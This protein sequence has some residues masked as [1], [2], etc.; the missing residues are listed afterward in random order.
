MRAIGLA[1]S[2]LAYCGVAY[3]TPADCGPRAL[4]PAPANLAKILKDHARWLATQDSPKPKGKQADLSYSDLTAVDLAGAD[5]KMAK[6]T[7]SKLQGAKLDGAVLEMAELSCVLADA[8]SFAGADLFQATLTNASL[9]GSKFEQAKLGGAMLSNTELANT[10]FSGADM[11]RANLT[12]AALRNTKLNEA[13]FADV[14]LQDALWQP[15]DLPEVGTMGSATNLRTMRLDTQSPDPGGMTRLVAA[16]REAGLEDRAKEVAHARERAMISLDF[17]K[18]E[19]S[20]DIVSFGRGWLRLVAGCLTD[21]G[22][23]LTLGLVV[24][25]AWNLLFVPVYFGC[26]FSRRPDRKTGISRILPEKTLVPDPAGERLTT[27]DRVERLAPRTLGGR[28]FW[29]VCFAGVTAVRSGIG[30]FNLLEGLERFVGWKVM[31]VTGWLGWFA[32]AQALVSAFIIGC[33][34][35]AYFL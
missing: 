23:S 32:N 13:R 4:A 27:E 21:Y 28:L 33:L 9:I 2:L 6:F 11:R 19:K 18:W 15:V 1:L 16:L 17:A 34:V 24:V 31:A 26:G 8:A 12:S 20:S 10:D 5:L 25:L 29:S 3:G 35:Y 30:P 22:L 14:D 7:G